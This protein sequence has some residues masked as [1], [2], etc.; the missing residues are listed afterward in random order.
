MKEK[1]V[2]YPDIREIEVA[3]RLF[4]RIDF[5]EQTFMVS[6]IKKTEKVAKIEITTPAA[7]SRKRR[8]KKGRKRVTQPSKEATVLVTF[9]MPLSL[10]STLIKLSNKAKKSL[11]EYIVGVL[12]DVVRR[13]SGD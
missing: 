13:L 3:D 11:A 8:K 2:K 4:V 5:D 7:P 9:S 10:H 6:P 1:F 12:L